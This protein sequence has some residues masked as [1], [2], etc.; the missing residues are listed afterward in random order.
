MGSNAEV[1]TPIPR[2]WR[3]PRQV[4][5]HLAA[6]LTDWLN[7]MR[8]MEQDLAVVQGALDPNHD[9]ID[10]TQVREWVT[11]INA[12]ASELRHQVAGRLQAYLLIAADLQREVD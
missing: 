7:S 8:S 5:P 9:E 10:I 4:M 12:R 2:E 11:A 3:D 6:E 1:P